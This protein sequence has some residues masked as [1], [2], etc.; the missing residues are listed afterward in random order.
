MNKYFKAAYLFGLLGGAFCGI[1]FLVIYFLDKDPISFT[2]IFGYAIIPVFVFLG[3]KNFKDRMNEREMSF[4]QAMTVGFFVYSILALIS[5]MV[6]FVFLNVA[7][8]IF[9]GYRTSNLDLLVE[10]KEV[11]IAQLDQES[12]DRTHEN[13]SNMT[14]F[15]VAV[16]DF[17]RKVFPGLFFTIIISIILKRTKN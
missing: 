5:A 16:N 10:K 14:I 3:I 2:E 13:I 8:E 1:A 17:L 15:D 4:G 12:Y 7:P 9:D 11:L 6:I